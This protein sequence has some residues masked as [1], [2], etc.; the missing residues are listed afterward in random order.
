MLDPL[1]GVVSS[2]T[3]K[4]LDR[5]DAKQTFTGEQTSSTI[6][7]RNARHSRGAMTARLLV[8]RNSYGRVTLMH[9]TIRIGREAATWLAVHVVSDREKAVL[10]GSKLLKAGHFQREDKGSQGFTDDESVFYTKV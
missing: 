8:W 4:K 1:H 9:S 10:L 6:N 5:S 7:S 3:Q 2:R